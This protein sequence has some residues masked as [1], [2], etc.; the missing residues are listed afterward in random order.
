MVTYFGA[1]SISGLFEE[2]YL[3]IRKFCSMGSF[4]NAPLFS[5][6]T[7]CSVRTCMSSKLSYRAV[8]FCSGPIDD[9]CKKLHH[10]YIALL[11]F[12]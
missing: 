10:L 12:S 2:Y 6:Y 5:C 4:K 3:L 1:T 7:I 9:T 11:I 8:S